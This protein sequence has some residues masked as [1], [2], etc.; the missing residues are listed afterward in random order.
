MALNTVR[1][2]TNACFSVTGQNTNGC[3]AMAVICVTVIPRFTINV[4]PAIRWSV[5][6]DLM[7]QVTMHNLLQ[8]TLHYL[9]LVCLQLILFVDGWKYFDTS[10]FRNG[11]CCAI[12]NFQLH[13]RDKDSLN[14]VSL[15]AMATVSVQNCTGI[16][17]KSL[18]HIHL[19]PNPTRDKFYLEICQL[20]TMIRMYVN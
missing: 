17:E 6:M 14:C 1:L 10:F 11:G 2:T 12:F 9:P 3:K 8:I 13:R 4:T 15:P 16:D 18:N 7:A 5:I 19:F 20:I